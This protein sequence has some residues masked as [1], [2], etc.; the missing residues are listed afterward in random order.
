MKQIDTRNK[1]GTAD[2]VIARLIIKLP[3]ILETFDMK[4]EEIAA[5]LR[6]RASDEGYAWIARFQNADALG[7]VYFAMEFINDPATN[8]KRFRCEAVEKE[9]VGTIG[10]V[11][12]G[13]WIDRPAELNLWF[14]KQRSSE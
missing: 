11:T 10:L 8:Q 14:K 6:F 13:E 1:K 7:W 9:F 2:Y 12:S 4:A 5:I 3:E